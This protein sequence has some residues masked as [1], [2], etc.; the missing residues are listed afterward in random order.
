[1]SKKYK[2]PVLTVLYQ[3][4]TIAQICEEVLC[5]RGRVKELESV[6]EKYENLLRENLL[7]EPKE[8]KE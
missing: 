7:R 8:E 4:N 2:D 6:K 3:A 1:M 5:L